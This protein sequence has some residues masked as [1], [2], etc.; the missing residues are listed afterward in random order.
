MVM[1]T[2]EPCWL[3]EL[4]EVALSDQSTTAINTGSWKSI[5]PR[6]EDKLPPCS[7][8]CP[9]G[10]DISKVLL[11]L[12]KSD[13]AGAAKLLRTTNPIP[14]TLGRVCPHFC[15]SQCNRDGFGGSIAVHMLER[16]LGDYSLADVT[17]MELRPSSKSG[18]TVAVIGAGPAGISAAYAL[19]LKGHEVQVFD[20]K[21][22]P[23]GYLR[24]G[25]PD[26]R[27]PKTTLDREIALAERVGVKFRPNTRVG[28][29]IAIDS[30]QNQFHAVIVAVGLHK[31]R[32]LDVP[33]ADHPNVYSGVDL[34]ESILGGE[35]PKL[36]RVVAVIGGG[37]TAIDVARSV[38]RLGVKPIVVYRR[39]E[40]EMPAISSEVEEAKKEGVKF[41]F[42]A[43]PA[44]VVTQNGDLIA[45]D[46]QKMKLGNPDSSGRRTPVAIPNEKFR[47]EVSGVIVATGELP[48]LSFVR[49][50]NENYEGYFFAGDVATG[51]GTVAAAVGH[52]LQV[53]ASVDS[54]LRTGNRQPELADLR[55]LWGRNVNVKKVAAAEL[56][57]PAYFHAQP[58]PAIT[59]IQHRLA[60]TTFDEI[61]QGF[62]LQEARSEARRCLSCGTCNECLNCYY[63]CPDIAV[64][65]EPH[66]GGL[67]IDSMHCKG[68]GICVEECPRSA[69]SM[70]EV[71]R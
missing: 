12:A 3:D 67:T 7:E 42:L 36:P 43:T 59:T 21:P 27:L 4:A 57:N 37:N 6:Y 14:A 61:V 31:S 1:A 23:G 26:Y 41:Q 40:K 53:A 56:L 22:K 65:R 49:K 17:D 47:I 29:D 64:H 52:G 63:W 71:Q 18:K 35:A 48:D 45:L 33:G 60:P 34:L 11:L 2:I 13:V 16:F 58:R 24:T 30:L 9:A 28:R 62:E 55:R 38:L 32:A 66:N 15:E 25:I 10:N 70:G 19:T 69:M 44:Q 8:L 54:Y 20:D 39:T 68:C 46:C 50:E 51:Q 5:A